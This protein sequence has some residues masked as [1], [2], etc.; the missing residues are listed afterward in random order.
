MAVKDFKVRKGLYV[1]DSATIGTNLSVGGHTVVTGNMTI[2]G[3]T[4]ITGG[5]AG[6]YTGFDS[7]LATKNTGDLTEHISR[8]YYTTARADSAI[9]VYVDS[10]FLAG[11]LPE[12]VTDN[13]AHTLTNKT[14]VDPIIDS[15]PLYGH[16]WGGLSMNKDAN[17]A[18]STQSLFSLISQDSGKAAGLHLGV[19]N[20]VNHLIAAKGDATDNKLVI[21]L[22]G[23]NSEINIIRNIGT[24]PLKMT[25]PAVA[26]DLITISNTGRIKTNNT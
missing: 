9:N 14:I 10:A 1:G 17:F 16:Y 24:N 2:A 6:R 21:G 7:D 26:D 20:Q 3:N 22:D 12:Y 5:V 19:Q 4:T 13:D 15:T 23:T 18:D 11:R 8:L 25:A